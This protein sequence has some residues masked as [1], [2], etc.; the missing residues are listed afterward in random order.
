MYSN[1]RLDRAII[2][3]YNAFNSSNLNPECCKQC[4]V[5]NILDNTDSWKHFSDNHGSTNLNYIGSVNQRLGKS[6]NG[7]TPLELLKIEVIF[8]TACGYELPFKHNHLKPKN[9]TDTH[10]LFSALCEV[11]KFLCDLDNVKNE[12]DYTNLFKTATVFKEINTKKTTNKFI[13]H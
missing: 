3:L 9:P 2:K 10:I 13:A 4:A 5:G 12:L 1:S 7:Y 11:I 8:L 6:F